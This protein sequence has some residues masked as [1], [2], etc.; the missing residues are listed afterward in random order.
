[1]AGGS[2]RT[3]QRNVERIRARLATT[4]LPPRRLD[5]VIG[6]LLECLTRT[7]DMG[8]LLRAAAP[9]T[10]PR[11]RVD[12]AVADVIHRTLFGLLPDVNVH[13]PAPGHPPTL[14]FGEAMWA[15]VQHGDP[16]RDLTPAGRRTLEALLHAGRD[17]FI[18]RGY[19]GAR[20]DDIVDAAGVS[21]GAF[22]RYFTNKDDL[23]RVVAV[24]AIR[25]VG[26]AFVGIPPV[27]TDDGHQ[28]GSLRSWLRNYN[29][30]HAPEA[31]VIQVWVD[32]ARQDGTLRVDSAAAV[33]WGRRRMVQV[34]APRDFGDVETEALA[35]VALLGAFGARERPANAADAAAYV[36]ERGFF[37]R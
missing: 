27:P 8:S 12:D 35:L 24:R 10:F 17:V 26:S 20:V 37:G 16:E 7:H 21:H 3:S 15:A 34:L 14:D 5:P 18:E 36:I 4:S 30:A 1:V 13:P 22:Y 29:A 28:P 19:Y 2:V 9:E 11:E 33:D 32:A 31:A 23:A 6:L 25:G